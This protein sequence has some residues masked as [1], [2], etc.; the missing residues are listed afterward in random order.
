MALIPDNHSIL[1][2]GF[3]VWYELPEDAVP[4]TLHLLIAERA[5]DPAKFQDPGSPHL[6]VLNRNHSVGKQ[7][8][9]VGLLSRANENSAG[10]LRTLSGAK[11]QE[12]LRVLGVALD[13]FV[14]HRVCTVDNVGDDG[15]DLVAGAVYD[16]IMFYAPKRR[17]G[18]DKRTLMRSF[19]ACR[20]KGLPCGFGRYKVLAKAGVTTRRGVGR[21]TER[22]TLLPYGSEF[23][24][25]EARSAITEDSL[26]LRTLH[27]WLDTTQRHFDG[28]VDFGTS[29]LQNV[30]P[31]E[32]SF[33]NYL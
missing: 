7:K 16:L 1:V 5:P 24:A 23:N 8:L 15:S 31:I 6:L 2:S 33:A 4:G 18:R 9:E 28:D 22:L 11:A 17:S 32:E 10:V 19:V 27:G 13:T 26:C 3:T 25:L 29:R 20:K 21:L 14:H 30:A 12:R